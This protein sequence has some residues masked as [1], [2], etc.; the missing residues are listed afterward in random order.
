MTVLSGFRQVRLRSDTLAVNHI[1]LAELKVQASTNREPR[2]ENS[3][4]KSQYY[5]K[6][7]R[8]HPLLADS[9]YNKY[10]I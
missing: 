10:C 6:Q 2:T 3:L 7:K 1:G 4:Q 5:N 8:D 9:L